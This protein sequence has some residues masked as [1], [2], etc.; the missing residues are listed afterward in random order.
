MPK[1]ENFSNRVAIDGRSYPKNELAPVDNGGNLV[2]VKYTH[3]ADQTDRTLDDYYQQNY[4]DWTDSSDNPYPTKQALLDDMNAFFLSSGN[5]GGGGN[6]E[7]LTTTETDPFIRY[8]PDGVGGVTASD[9]QNQVVYFGN[10]Y[11]DPIVKFEFDNGVDQTVK[12]F[13]KSGNDFT[14]I[15]TF[16][17]AKTTE[18]FVN[19]IGGGLFADYNGSNISNIV[20]TLNGGDVLIGNVIEGLRLLIKD[21]LYFYTPILPPVIELPVN[22]LTD[23]ELMATPALEKTGFFYYEFSFTAPFDYIV[24]AVY[25]TTSALSTSGKVMLAAYAPASSDEDSDPLS[26]SA[27][28]DNY[29]NGEDGTE[30]LPNA[31]SQRIPLRKDFE[32]F[33]GQD[34]IVRFWSDTQMTWLGGDIGGG[35]FHPAYSFDLT[36]LQIQQDLAYV[37]FESFKSSNNFLYAGQTTEGLV[38]NQTALQPYQSWA[39]TP[40]KNGDYQFMMQATTSIDSTF[41]DFIIQFNLYEDTG[42][43]LN[44]LYN[45]LTQIQESQDA[46]G[47]GVLLNEI[48]NENIIGQ[49]NTG[50]NQRI[51]AVSIGDYDL[52]IGTNYVLQIEF[53]SNANNQ[54]AAIYSSY[55][56]KELKI[57]THP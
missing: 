36:F 13:K 55:M 15:F 23:T 21:T 52:Q 44:L 51:A 18:F 10:T 40:V 35:V 30:V 31:I 48:E 4:F 17:S 16:G 5:G 8:V 34:M 9:N 29:F 14:E 1:L 33:Q 20:R 46:G 39:F 6:I 49:D 45:F 22:P 57:E 26:A 37:R 43:G 24:S 53:G 25:V 50:T 28:K 12:V 19:S 41:T 7:D 54:Q 2:S 3:S 27:D 47:G 32:V 11:N 42:G 56:S 38:S